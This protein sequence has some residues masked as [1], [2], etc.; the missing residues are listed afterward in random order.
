M[1]QRRLGR[2]G[3]TVGEIGLG[4]WAIGGPYRVDTGSEVVP[5]GFGS[6]DDAASI[7]A[8]HR[9]LDLGA[10]LFDTANVY[11]V[12]H[13]EEVLGRALAGRRDRA[14]VV[15]KFAT[16]FDASERLARYADEPPL[17]DAFVRDTLDASLRRLR[18]DYV[19]VY[20]LHSGSRPID[21]VPPLLE[22]LEALVREGK[23]RWYGWS[24]D[25]A[26]RAAAFAA[27]E[28]CSAVEFVLNPFIEAGDMLDVLAEHDLGGLI[29]SPL[30]GGI[31][32]GKFRPDYV[33]AQDDGRYGIDFTVEPRASRLRAVEAMRP[34]LTRDGLTVTQAALAWILTRSD[35]VVPIPG[36]KT[37]EQ[38]EENLGAAGQRLDE[39]QLAAVE[40]AVRE[41]RVVVRP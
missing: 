23:I 3:L 6:V 33:F 31:L 21:E 11:G 27:G 22:I 13:S 9:A 25:D 37:R 5:M 40:D 29:K 17:T 18:T 39:E 30:G 24:T 16:V 28:H 41:L 19:D 10:T 35:R 34:A 4:C 15:T 36:F 14:V 26:K 8:I 7:A 20:L 12:G 32:T 2:S 38:V 1:E